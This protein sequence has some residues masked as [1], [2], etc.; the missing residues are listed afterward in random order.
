MCYPPRS[1]TIQTGFGHSALVATQI[2][3]G[4]KIAKDGKMRIHFCPECGGYSLA[5]AS[6]CDECQAELPED[7]WAEVTEEELQLLEYADD[8]DLPGGL[9]TWEYDVLKLKSNA[10]EGGINYTGALLRRMGEK[11]WELVNVSPLGDKGGARYGI[12]KRTWDSNGL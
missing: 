3:I 10:D 9:P 6:S 8:F 1:N 11:G 5:P 12:F 2:F 7:S 4:R